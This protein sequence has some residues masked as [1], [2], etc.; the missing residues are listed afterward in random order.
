VISG[1]LGLPVK[2]CGHEGVEPPDYDAVRVESAQGEM[3]VLLRY[4]PRLSAWWCCVLPVAAE[5]SDRTERP[6]PSERKAP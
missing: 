2:R 1:D 6:V 5:S 3:I 4:E